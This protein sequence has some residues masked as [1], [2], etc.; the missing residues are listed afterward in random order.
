MQSSCLSLL[1]R[2]GATT[3]CMFPLLSREGRPQHRAP[4]QTSLEAE[5][6]GTFCLD[7]N[8]LSGSRPFTGTDSPLPL[9][10][11]HCR[12]SGFLK[13][14]LEDKTLKSCSRNIRPM[15]CGHSVNTVSRRSASGLYWT[16]GKV[17]SSKHFS[18]L[19]LASSQRPA[20][21]HSPHYWR[22]SECTEGCW[23]TSS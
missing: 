18:G 2:P 1:S 6:C 15:H 14:F 13:C 4:L 12:E 3:P 22:L 7:G 5:F 20:V 10:N 23:A 9:T 16:R 11:T 19:A 8:C 21:P 17:Q